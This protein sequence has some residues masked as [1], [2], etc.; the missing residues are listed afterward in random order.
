MPLEGSLRAGAATVDITP[1][2]GV[3]VISSSYAKRTDGAEGVADALHARAL[4]VDS[5]EGEGPAAVV[6][7]DLI[8]VPVEFTAAVRQ[9]VT[10]LT[11]IPPER[12]MLAATH[13]HFVPRV[14]GLKLSASDGKPDPV[15]AEWCESIAAKIAGAV[16]DAVAAMRPARASVAVGELP[17]AHYNRRTR[18]ADGSV[19]TNFRWPADPGEWEFRPVDDSVTVLKLAAAGDD[20]PSDPERLVASV[21]VYACHAV[22]GSI[23]SAML[24]SA[25]HPGVACG[26]VEEVTG[27]PCLFLSGPAGDV[28]P[29]IRGRAGRRAV[30]ESLAGEVLRLL[31]WS[32]RG[33]DGPVR[34]AAKRIELER[35]ARP[36]R[37]QA[38]AALREAEA[39]Q[40]SSPGGESEAVVEMWRARLEKVDAEIDAWTPTVGTEIQALRWGPLAIGAM[41]GEITTPVGVA[42][43]EGCRAEI[44]VLVSLANDYSG[45]MLVSDDLARGGYEA[46][47]SRVAPGAAEELARETAELAGSLG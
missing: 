40:A 24:I 1:P 10:E 39:K 6:S 33:L 26:L 31:P 23:G 8:G 35:K 36:S 32:Q 2:V 30:G 5:G 41:G 28:V 14:V 9:G 12:L 3:P 20:A 19:V 47:V 18:A 29:R 21:V 25:D 4:A 38:E 22:C 13:S 17:E 43:K 16:G 44:P 11:G 42:F 34:M 7:A 45:Y 46:G 15:V 37:E 27:A